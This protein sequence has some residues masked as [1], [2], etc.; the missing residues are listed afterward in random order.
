MP[1]P[2]DLTDESGPLPDLVATRRREALGLSGCWKANL[3]YWRGT[4]SSQ[5][6]EVIT[7]IVVNE[8]Y[9]YGIVTLLGIVVSV[10]VAVWS[11]VAD[12][13]PPPGRMKSYVPADGCYEFEGV[14]SGEKL[15][16][17]MHTSVTP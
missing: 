11:F 16:I 2:H 4:S 6:K 3:I 1:L 5:D 17:T 8:L 10:A 13:T 14:A 7:M 12:V 9:G 15:R